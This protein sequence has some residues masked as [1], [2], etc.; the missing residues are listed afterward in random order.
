MDNLAIQALV[1]E[2]RPR[3]L[4]Q[5][6]LQA[7]QI[8]PMTV[9]LELTGRD[10]GHLLFDLMD[11]PL[12]FFTKKNWA[13]ETPSPFVAVM[14]KWLAGTELT[15]IHKNLDERAV[16]FKFSTSAREGRGTELELV[17]ECVP[18]WANL[19]LLN[20]AGSI[21][22][23]MLASRADRRKLEVGNLYVPPRVHGECSLRDFI[24][25]PAT[26]S[27]HR[28]EPD[29]LARRVRGLGPIFAREVQVR[30]QRGCGTPQQVLAD[31]VETIEGGRFQPRVYTLPDRI[32]SL[33]ISPIELQSLEQQ[34]TAL[35]DSVTE[36]VEAVFERQI[37]AALFEKERIELQRD[38]QASMKKF[39]RLEEKLAAETRE[40][41]RETGLQKFADLILVQPGEARPQGG[42][43]ELLDVFDPAQPKLTI[44]ID[45][46]LSPVANAQRFYQKAK[47]ARR[48]LE[49]IKA[50]QDALHQ[51]VEVL[52]ACAKRISEAHSLDK[53]R[54]IS[55]SLRKEIPA[56]REAARLVATNE[57]LSPHPERRKKKCRV[58]RSQ[59][60]YE[61]LV[62][63]NSKENDLVTTRYAQAEDYWFHVAD[64]GGSHVVL[65]NPRREILET[66]ADFLE[67]A[68]LAAYFSQARN[69]RNVLVH[70]TQKRFV[71]KPKRAKP[72]LVKLLKF[73]SITVEP[74]LPS[75]SNA[76]AEDGAG[77]NA[78]LQNPDSK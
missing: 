51:M 36:A 59:N 69:A 9:A 60:A 33:W 7:A 62:G 11:V 42:R 16:H 37:G 21:L 6:C 26:H 70:W 73:Q 12:F 1:T 35:F 75:P 58:F 22:G 20:D 25:S 74:N 66:T 10:P 44:E 28:E 64:Y 68:Q 49:K 61:I 50:R 63:R 78:K 43:L 71:K 24:S 39:K 13:L 47:R 46:R 45:S 77:R 57:P 48:G 23:A 54:K 5:H 31:I 4:H 34:P 14:R 29:E 32:Q 76:L 17:A 27:S 65:R 56:T 72:G 30:S 19:Y 18:R 41:T 8:N 38:V 53:L 40:F 55:S 52:G 2:L 15:S 67:A 3:L